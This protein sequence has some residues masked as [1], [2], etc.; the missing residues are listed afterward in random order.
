MS[1]G[2]TRRSYLHSQE[3]TGL[4]DFRVTGAGWDTWPN[5]GGLEQPEEV[6]SFDPAVCP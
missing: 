1:S 4:G 2:L 5:F 6:V 3:N